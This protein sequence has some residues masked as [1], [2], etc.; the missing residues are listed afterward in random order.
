MNIPVNRVWHSWYHVAKCYS[1]L[2]TLLHKFGLNTQECANVPKNKWCKLILL[3]MAN[4]LCQMLPVKCSRFVKLSTLESFNHLKFVNK[5]PVQWSPFFGN[6]AYTFESIW[7]MLYCFIY[8]VSS[9]AI[10]SYISTIKTSWYLS[11]Y[12]LISL[13]ST[14]L[15]STFYLIFLTIFSFHCIISN[16]MTTVIYLSNEINLDLIVNNK[17][18]PN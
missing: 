8:P 7:F 4:V 15:L 12:W 13:F 18:I 17:I 10:W 1:L 5:G 2:I 14:E 16:W 3:H 11:Y 9:Y 6:F